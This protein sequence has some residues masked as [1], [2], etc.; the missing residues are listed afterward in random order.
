MNNIIEFKKLPE[1]VQ[2][3]IDEQLALKDWDMIFYNP[4]TSEAKLFCAGSQFMMPKPWVKVI[5]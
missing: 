1:I 3:Y 2:E 4:V 5:Y